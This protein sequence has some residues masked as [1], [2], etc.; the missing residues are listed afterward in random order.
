M[1]T[2]LMY[3]INR[4]HT[5]CPCPCLCA[6]LNAMLRMRRNLAFGTRIHNYLL[7][8]YLFLLG[9]FFSQ[10][11]WDVTPEFAGL[12]QASTS[13]LSLVG[14]WYAAVLLFIAMFLWVVD[15]LF[16]VWDVVGTLLRGVAFFAGY[17]LV[18][19]FSTITQDGLVLH[20]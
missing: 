20:F 2:M 4:L 1:S 16:P 14:L 19:F 15:K 6:I 5:Y 7:L 17:V 10:L 8:L 18:T 13:F 12:V 11:W 3:R 9:L